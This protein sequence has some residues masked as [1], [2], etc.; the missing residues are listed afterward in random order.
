LRVREVGRG[1]HAWCRP[2]QRIGA[3]RMPVAVLRVQRRG[4]KAACGRGANQHAAA[5]Q[6]RETRAGRADE[7][8]VAVLAQ[9][10]EPQPG[11]VQFDRK[12]AHGAA[13]YLT[14]IWRTTFSSRNCSASSTA[15]S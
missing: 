2:R 12:Q 7:F 13:A 1:G 10:C 8:A 6:Q 15:R 14:S 3:E 11:I 4:A 9:A 5:V